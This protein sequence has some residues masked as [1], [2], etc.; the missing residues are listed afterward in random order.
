LK[1]GRKSQLGS[2]PALFNHETNLLKK[3][4]GLGYQP[5]VVY[6]IGA[7]NGVWSDT[8]ALVLTDSE[9]H[10]FEPLADAVDFYRYDLTERLQRRRR[11]HLHPVALGDQ[12]GTAEFFITHD[13]FGSSMLNR[14]D[15]PEVKLRTTVR[16]VRLDDY[17]VERGL[18]PAN[19]I[20][21]DCQG[22]ERL[23]LDG[24][25]VALEQADVVFLE[26]WLER[27]YGPETPLLGEMIEHLSQRDF[28]LVEL[29]EKFYSDRGRLYSVDAFFF[30]AKF[31]QRFVLPQD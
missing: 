21:I 16:K 9:Y 27:G 5:E 8:I 29:G 14:G 23:I 13:A 19:L 28:G 22:A 26:T 1:P 6:D 10:L 25:P 17:T 30:S 24:G 12:S 3:L 4:K 11:F 18:P 7:S 31:S 20:K 2:S 15:I